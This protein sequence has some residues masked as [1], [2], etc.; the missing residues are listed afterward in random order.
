MLRS[1]GVR[2]VFVH[3]GDYNVTQLADGELRETVDGF[4]RSAQVRAERRLLEVYAF[5]LV[6]FAVTAAR[7]PLIPI[8]AGEFRVEVS[9]GSDRAAFL[10]DGDN[11]SRWIGMQ[12]GSSA[13]T[14]RFGEQ[15]DIARI[16]LQLAERSLMD[17]PRELQI[18]AEDKDGRSRVLYRATPF[19]EFFAGFLRD[20]F[21]PSMRIDL[22]RNDTMVLRVRDVATYDTW[23]SV[24]E[25]RLWRRP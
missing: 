24:H 5:D 1:L 3:P 12:D 13:I 20:R 14:A 11:D 19:P 18:E 7:E 2:Y 17:Y 8:P 21:Y 25:L 9:Q 16:E 6:P 4:R 23:W 22:P 15:R 10:V